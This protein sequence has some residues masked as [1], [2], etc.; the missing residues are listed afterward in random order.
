MRFQDLETAATIGIPWLSQRFDL[1]QV[2]IDLNTQEPFAAN[3]ICPALVFSI[4]LGPRHYRIGLD[5]AHLQ[6]RRL[7]VDAVT[8]S[9]KR[10]SVKTVSGD[11]DCEFLGFSSQSHMTT[12]FRQCLGMTP[13]QLR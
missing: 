6:E 1:G 11:Q 3:F 12:L 8:L 2:Q 9:P 7:A 13:G 10:S 4:Q 5:S